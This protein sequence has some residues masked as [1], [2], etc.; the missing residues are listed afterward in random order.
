MLMPSAAKASTDALRAAA[1][2]VRLSF[3]LERVARHRARLE[4]RL[5]A[6]CLGGR[7]DLLGVLDDSGVS[8]AG[9]EPGCGERVGQP[10]EVLDPERLHLVHAHGGD[11]GERAVSI[12]F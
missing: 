10:V 2:V 9:L 3:S 5:H 4:D 7:K 11:R 8:T 6:Q 1:K 12:G